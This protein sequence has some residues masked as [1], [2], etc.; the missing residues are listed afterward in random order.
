MV[1]I[2]R[3]IIYNINIPQGGTRGSVRF[4][5]KQV[6]GSTLPIVTRCCTSHYDV[7]IFSALSS[8]LCGK[9]PVTGDSPH[10]G[11][12]MRMCYSSEQTVK[13]TLDW[14]VIRDAM[15]GILRLP[16]ACCIGLLSGIIL[17]PGTQVDRF[18]IWSIAGVLLVGPL[19][20]NFM[21]I[22]IKIRTY[23]LKKI[24]LNM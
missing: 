22:V 23:S 18:I 8:P 1:Y 21:E 4:K 12:W 9:P 16:M 20:T 2:H 24:Y 17:N 5:N 11:T 7:I 3:Y 13:L 10:K 14:Q 19:G 15:T 6:L